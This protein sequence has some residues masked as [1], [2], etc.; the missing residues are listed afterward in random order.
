MPNHIMSPTLSKH[1]LSIHPQCQ[2]AMAA[3]ARRLLYSLL[4][5]FWV[6]ND[7]QSTQKERFGRQ[8]TVPKLEWLEQ[9]QTECQHIMRFTPARAIGVSAEAATGRGAAHQLRLG[10]LHSPPSLAG[11][12]VE[13]PA[14]EGPVLL[15]ALPQDAHACHAH[16]GC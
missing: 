12:L 10:Q 11:L 5:L 15:I 13:A 14:L 3:T 8:Q 6:L 7:T 2:R 4:L 1:S 16:L 9:L